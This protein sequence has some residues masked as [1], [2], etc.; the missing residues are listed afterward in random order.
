MNIHAE[1]FAQRSRATSSRST[2]DLM[3]DFETPVSVYAKL[4]DA[5]P[6]LP[7][8]VGRGRGEPRP[9]QLHRLPAAAGL[10]LRTGDDG[11]PPAGQARRSGFRP[12]PTR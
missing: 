5:R 11:D 8:G 6:L 1:A 10:R 7:A 9:L 4:K 2:S 3:A 12:R